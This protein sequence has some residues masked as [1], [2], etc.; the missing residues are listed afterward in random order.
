MN[1]MFLTLMY[2]PNK[3][4]EFRKKSKNGLQMQIQNY[5]EAFLEGINSNLLKED[6]FFGINCPPVGLYPMQYKELFIPKTS[7]KNV[8]NVETF[9]F[10]F[11]KQWFRQLAVIKQLKIWLSKNPENPIVLVYTQYMPFMQALKKIKKQYPNLKVCVIVTDLPNKWGLDSGRKGITKAIEKYMGNKSLNLLKRMDSYVLLTEPMN[12]IINNT[13][14]PYLVL[15]G[16][17]KEENLSPK[18]LEFSLPYKTNLPVVFYSGTL[19]KEVGIEELLIAFAEYNTAELWICGNGPYLER[20]K[21]MSIK[22]SNIK[23]L[24]LLSLQ[25]VWSIQ[26]KVTLLIN[27]R[28]SQSIYTKYSF[29]SKTLEY[30]RSGTP[31][32]CYPLEGIPKE[33]FQYLNLIKEETSDGIK[34]ALN[35]FFSKS[36]KER[37]NIAYKAK[38]FVLSKKSP[39][40]QGEKLVSFLNKIAK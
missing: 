9:N 12:E 35:Y 36:E 21:E 27:P 25:E 1:L 32:L 24:G 22:H 2:P 17:I 15:E 34:T 7:V 31:V 16:M 38:D 13:N 4:D 26:K 39:N 20:V 29:P 6:K 10:P 40:F 19:N 37:Q 28:N 33:Y 23:Y 14:K 8:V 5:Q 3:I 30:M 18:S 11:F